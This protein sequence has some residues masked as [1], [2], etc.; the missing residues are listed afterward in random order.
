MIGRNYVIAFIKP[1]H[2]IRHDERKTPGAP[3]VWL[4]IVPERRQLDYENDSRSTHHS[5]QWAALITCPRPP[6]GHRKSNET[7]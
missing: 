4:I 6:Q 1:S 2:F 3:L 7:E 5:Q